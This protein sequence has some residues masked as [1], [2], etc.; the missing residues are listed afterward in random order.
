M[1][2]SSY[3]M[4]LSASLV[5][6][7]PTLTV[8]AQN[9]IINANPNPTTYLPASQISEQQPGSKTVLD[10]NFSK[11]RV[12]Q[13]G[14]LGVVT[15]KVNLQEIHSTA[16]KP[17]PIDSRHTTKL[18]TQVQRA[19][20]LEPAA[21]PSAPLQPTPPTPIVASVKSPTRKVS[22]KASAQPTPLDRT[23]KFAEISPKLP[24]PANLAVLEPD[25][26]PPRVKTAIAT[27]I[28]PLDD[29]PAASKP[30]RK[31]SSKPQSKPQS[32]S[33]I[34]KSPV[35]KP[36]VT[37]T[38]TINPLD[39][40]PGV[41][42][43]AIA[44]PNSVTGVEVKPS[45][46]IAAVSPSTEP[47]TTNSSTPTS[48]PATS[49]TSATSANS[50][51][52]VAIGLDPR[53]P[54]VVPTTPSQVKIER[55]Q[56]LS[57]KEALELSDRT[58]PTIAQARIAV[59]RARAVL[60][61]ALAE[62]NPTL[63]AQS[64][65]NYGNSSF[66][67]GRRSPT[68][69]TLN[70][71]VTLNYNLFT[72]GRVDANIRVAENS[73]RVAEADLNRISQTTRLRI[74]TAY[75]DAQNADGQV[76][77]R[78]QQVKNA[79]RSLQDTQAL[80][81]AG[82]GTKFDVLQSQ[83]QLA[84]AKQTLSNARAQQSITRRELAR[85]LS[86]PSNLALFPS[87]EVKPNEDWKLGLEET[88]LLAYKNRSE[89]DIAKL[90]REIAN[91]RAKAELANL[92]PQLNIFARLDH[93]DN[94]NQAGDLTLGYTLGASL[95]WSIF[96][97]GV[98][99]AR[100][101]QSEA[102]RALAESRFTEAGDQARFDVESA[103]NNLRARQEQ[104]ESTTLAVQQATE[105]LRLSRL[106]LSAGVGTQL[107]VLRSEDDLTQADVNRLDAIVGF[108]LSLI[109]LQRAINGL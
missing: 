29:I 12:Q 72:S 11:P 1:R 67:I 36:A 28:N 85:Q 31:P 33:A 27:A 22:P 46:N 41:N 40:I 43:P 75:Y 48:T 30:D 3:W 95:N 91:D 73:L 98:A 37:A 13:N 83:V 24:R 42:K 38:A 97:G 81:R 18:I 63:S 50:A 59:E 25:N 53:Q 15:A 76:R 90:Q 104:I 107:E 10:A 44:K 56:P 51:N 23:V 2:F 19:S 84:N 52:K 66:F 86:Y 62:K 94:L 68:S 64:T 103:Y 93:N 89:L 80:E 108:N 74:A 47:A 32:N 70:S 34:A 102:D 8:N 77:I 17:T 6:L 54:L 61:Q 55:T 4:P 65:Y 45:T 96:D 99:N 57:L 26:S 79:E 109:Q 87:D 35:A 49:A 7:M 21:E 82:V 39:D 101:K 100:A 88:I 60:D 5:V 78:E 16:L 92:G 71:G 58:N 105:A 69:H 14:K 20:S 106:R 9:A